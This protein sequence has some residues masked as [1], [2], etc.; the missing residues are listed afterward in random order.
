MPAGAVN[1]TSISLSK[2]RS[3]FLFEPG[4]LKFGTKYVLNVTITNTENREE[5]S[6]S[7]AIDFQTEAQPAAGTVTVT[8]SSGVMFQDP[9][10]I[11]LSGF[12]SKNGPLTYAIYG[13]TSFNPFDSIRLSA[14][15]KTLTSGGATETKQLPFL[16][17]IQAVVT[18]SHGE[19]AVASQN[20]T[21]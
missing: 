13:I 6:T 17:G 7:K 10:T 20:V 1:D 2:D 15:D 11:K 12:S 4:A 21:V 9:F 8:P 3:T 5:G 19:I 14:G 18:D 16:V